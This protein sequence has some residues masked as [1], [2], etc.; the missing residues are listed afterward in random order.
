VYVGVK[1]SDTSSIVG[2]HKGVHKEQS[3]A[4]GDRTAEQRGGEEN[5]IDEEKVSTEQRSS[6]DAGQS[7]ADTNSEQKGPAGLVEG[8]VKESISEEQADVEQ[9]LVVDKKEGFTVQI[10]AF[11]EIERANR[12]VSE[13]NIRGYEP[14]ILPYVTSLGTN[15]YLVRIGKFKTREEARE[16]ATSF[17][18]TEGMEAIVERIE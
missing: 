8:Q 2:V 3:T 17:Q 9:E 14:Y 15:W 7:V 11:T 12:A 18:T 5:L 1:M 4:L 10:G 16:Y 13:L 6:S